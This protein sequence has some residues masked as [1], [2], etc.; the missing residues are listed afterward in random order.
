MSS[1]FNNSLESSN[2]NFCP[3]SDVCL[4]KIIKVFAQLIACFLEISVET[5]L[6]V[7]YKLLNL[8][9]SNPSL[10][11]SSLRSCLRSHLSKT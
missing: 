7:A 3:K 1:F 11:K 2:S 10:S 4:L 6:H 5:S 8:V 9:C